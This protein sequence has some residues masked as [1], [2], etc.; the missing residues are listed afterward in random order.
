[1]SSYTFDPHPVVSVAVDGLKERFPIRRI[2]CVGRN[3]EAH[4]REAGFDPAREPPFFFT[5]PTDAI[6]ETGATIPYPQE[7]KNYQYEIELVVAIGK[8]GRNIK[9]ANALEH[10]YGY[11]IG[12]DFTRRDLQ[13]VARD[14]GRPWDWGKS[15]DNSAG[16]SPIKRA[17]V[18]GHKDKGRIWLAVN[19]TVKQNQDLTDMIWKT[20]EIIEFCSRAMELKAGDLIYTGTPAGI[21]PIV[22]GD[23]ITG[24]I[25]GLADI[26]FTVGPALP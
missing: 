8:G 10:V 12:I 2:F 6:I 9:A 13:L 17:S 1:M 21:S 4:V 15:F 18:V 23:K 5:K 7:T 26:A 25:E 3:Y 19:G 20:P 11:T 24:E 16:I 22:P 14:N